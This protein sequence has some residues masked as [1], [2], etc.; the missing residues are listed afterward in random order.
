VSW[1]VRAAVA[2]VTRLT[3]VVVGLQNGHIHITDFGLSKDDVASDKAATTFCGTP[4]YLAP[5]ML[6]NR[7]TREGYGMAVDWCAPLLSL[8]RLPHVCQCGCACVC[9]LASVQ[10]VPW[11][12]DLRDADGVAAFLRQERKADV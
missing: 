4:E 12:T 11:H 8:C 7:R 9:G 6:I 2:L 3:C 10:V 1:V 5:E